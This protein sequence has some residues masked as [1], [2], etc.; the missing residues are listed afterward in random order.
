MVYRAKQANEARTPRP[1]PCGHSEAEAGGTAKSPALIHDNLVDGGFQY[2]HDGSN[3]SGSGIM[4]YDPG[5]SS[6]LKIGGY[7]RCFANTVIAI[8]NAGF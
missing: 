2:P 4:C 7:T 3:Y 5:T 8:E 6:G 1:D